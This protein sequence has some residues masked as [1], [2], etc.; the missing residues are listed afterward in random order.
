MG[1]GFNILVGCSLAFQRKF[2]EQ[3]LVPTLVHA[4]N[5]LVS[6]ERRAEWEGG[7]IRCWKVRKTPEAVAALRLKREKMC[8]PQPVHCLHQAPSSHN[9]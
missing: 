1:K 3:R 2:L 8:N 4:A 6:I 7:Q 5:W 9:L